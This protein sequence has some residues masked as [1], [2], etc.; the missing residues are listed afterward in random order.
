LTTVGPL[1]YTIQWFFHTERKNTTIF[2]NCSTKNK[3][4]D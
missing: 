1:F 4:Y 3:Y 2:W